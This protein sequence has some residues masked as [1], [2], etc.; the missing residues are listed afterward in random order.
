M[1]LLVIL[2]GAIGD[3]IL[4]LPS[5]AWLKQK[6]SPSWLE[7]WTERVNLPLANSSGYA[8]RVLALA[9]TGLDRWPTPETVI[10]RLKQF[11]RVL[12]WRGAAH[13]EWREEMCRQL[14]LID[15]LPG[16]PASLEL[17]A[18]DFRRRQ[19]ES[20]LGAD[21][22]FPCFP[23]IA[24]SLPE[25]EFAQEYLAVEMNQALPI[26][27]IHPGASGPRKKWGTHHFS[28]LA[29][30]LMDASNQILLCE[31]PL[32]GVTVDEVVCR[33]PA[34]RARTL[35]RQVRIDNLLRLAAVIQRCCLYIGND[36]GIGHL[37]AAVG[38]P[39][40]S[41]FIATDPRIWAPRAPRAKVLVCPSVNEVLEEAG[42]IE[43][44]SH[45]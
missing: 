17:H 19:L 30:R 23:Q 35:L 31:G 2:P 4:T 25:I 20:L 38:T 29:S 8:D 41:I 34:G 16:F 6:L 40:L 22:S 7:V 44:Q 43:Q 10:G 24:I 13:Q 18:M 21:D 12:S 1:K 11:D 5:V 32:D 27:M 45:S 14:P 15:F 42:R 28:H 37:A 33:L 26:V 39:T 36:S 3:F 9:D